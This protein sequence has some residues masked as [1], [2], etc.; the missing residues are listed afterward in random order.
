MAAISKGPWSSLPSINMK[1]AFSRIKAWKLLNT[2][3]KER[4]TRSEQYIFQKLILSTTQ[5]ISATDFER[6]KKKSPPE[7]G[8]EK[9]PFIY[10]PKKMP[11][12]S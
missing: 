8:V 4:S 9:R 3:L 5:T 7:A 10:L 11:G 6:K 1:S 12:Q 2:Q